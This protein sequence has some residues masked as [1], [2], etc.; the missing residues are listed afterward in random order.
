MRCHLSDDFYKLAWSDMDNMKNGV[1]GGGLAVALLAAYF[2]KRI[3][4]NS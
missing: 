3:V 4:Q 1:V 2:A